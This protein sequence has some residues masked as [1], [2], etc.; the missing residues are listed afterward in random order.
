[1]GCE[2]PAR[3]EHLSSR[4][5][6]E[7]KDIRGLERPSASTIERR[8]GQICC[9]SAPSTLRRATEDIELWREGQA[10]QI[11]WKSKQASEQAEEPA[12]C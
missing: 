11:E 1:M 12:R 2:V 6:N 7:R 8:W 4:A 9:K 3:T 5:N 10:L